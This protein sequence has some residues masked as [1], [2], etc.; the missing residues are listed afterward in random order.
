MKPKSSLG[1]PRTMERAG[2]YIVGQLLPQINNSFVRF[3]V[4]LVH[5]VAFVMLNLIMIVNNLWVGV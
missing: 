3:S 2:G 4:Q 1:G 5:W